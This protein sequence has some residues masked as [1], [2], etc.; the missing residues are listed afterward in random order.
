MAF[1]LLALAVVANPLRA[2]AT[3]D[4][5]LVAVGDRVRASTANSTIIG[6]ITRSD[7]RGIDLL[8]GEI[9]LPLPY[10]AMDRLERSRGRRSLWKEFAAGGVVIGALL[11][12]NG[13]E[14][15]IPEP[16]YGPDPGGPSRGDRA[17][18]AL[19]AGAIVGGVNGAIG[20]LF[21]WE[22]WESI[23]LG[24]VRDHLDPDAAPE[25]G[26][27]MPRPCA[28][29]GPQPAGNIGDSDR[30]VVGQRIRASTASSTFI[31]C[32]AGLTP[33]G[34]EL[35]DGET[36][37]SLP[38]RHLDRLE[39]DE[40]L[41]SRWAEGAIAGG[42]IGG[43]GGFVYALASGIGDIFSSCTG[44]C[45]WRE[46]ALPAMAAGALAGGVAG[47]A[48]GALLKVEAW[49][50]VPLEDRADGFRPMVG[51]ERHGSEGRLL[52]SVGGR[53]SFR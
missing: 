8:D 23:P 37:L 45:F 16:S 7:G 53:I 34:I 32:V 52:V 41:R 19:T 29:A 9:R 15:G 4:S 44:A 30:L 13:P 28:E 6:Q 31:G 50:P 10:R 38:Y 43:S 47:G 27:Q 24:D 51:L 1:I 26:L 36:R 22:A 35:M 2:Q 20:L 42:A 18:A 12:W 5:S 14:Q 40:G 49:E 11:G 21:R 39:V 17:K 46:E 25:S 3:G 33:Q 48:I